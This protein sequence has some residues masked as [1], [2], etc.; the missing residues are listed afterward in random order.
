MDEANQLQILPKVQTAH[1]VIDLTEDADESDVVLVDNQGP[2]N[3]V[4]NLSD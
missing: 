1:E 4:I 3:V 2:S